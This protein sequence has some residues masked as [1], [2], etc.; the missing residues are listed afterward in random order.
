MDYYLEAKPILFKTYSLMNDWFA[1]WVE[2][3]R[4]H[5]Q[6]DQVFSS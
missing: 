6:T 4:I 1:G 2:L 3:C 5:S